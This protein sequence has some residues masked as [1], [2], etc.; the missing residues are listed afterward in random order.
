[1]KPEAH[2]GDLLRMAATAGRDP[3]SLLDFSVNVR[4]EGPPE[5]IRAALFRAMTALAAYPSPHAEEAMLAAAR[6]HGMD[7]SRFVFGSGSNELIHA[8]AR[9]LR[10]RGVPSVRVVEP[11]FSEYAIACRL[12]GIKAIPVW[13]GIIEKNQCVP[14]TDTG[15][16]EAVPTRDLLDALTDA[17]EGSAVFLANPGNPSG[18]FRTPEECLRLMSS[19]SDLLW[20]ID[21]AFVEYAGTETEASVL[22]RL[23]KNGI[24]LRS[25]TKFHAVPGV[26]LGYLA[27]DA[28][29]AQ[30]IRDEL[31]AWSVNAFALAAAQAVFADTSDFAAQTRAENAE[32]RADLA[33]ALSSLPGIEVYPSAANYVL[34]RWPGAPHN[35]LGI[36]LKRFGIAVR[37][38]SNYH[39]LKDGSW[40]RA[41]VRFPEDHRRLAEALSAIRETTHGVSSSP[42]PETPASPESGNKDSINIKVLGRGGMGAWGKGGESPS[43]EGFLLP[44]PGISRRPRHTPALMLQGTSSNAGKSILAAAYCRIFRQDGYSVAPF[45]AQNMSLNSGVT[46]AGDEMGRAQIVQAQAALVD[47]DAR[48][49]PILLKPHSDTGSQVVVLGQPIGHMGVLDYFKKKKELW[50]TVTEA[51]D[52]LAADHDVMVL[53]GA[54][55]PGEINLKEHDVVNMRMA[56]H[57]R[58]SVLLVGDIDRGGVYASFLG[59]WMTFTDAERRLL[60]GYIV[61]RFRGDASL[62][63]P[64]HEYMLDHTGTPVLG[65]IPYIR[66]LNI[67]EEDM[68]GFSWG[69]TDC[70]E[71]KAGTLDIAVVMLRHVSNYTDFAPLAAEPDVRLRPVRRAEEWGDPDVVMLPGSKSVVPDLDDLRRSGLADNILGHAER[72]KW[73]FGICGGL[74]ILGRAILDPH[75]IESAAPEVPGLGLMDLRSTFAAD[76]TLVRVARAETPLGVPSG[77]YEIHHGLTDHGPSALPLFLRADRAYPSEAE[78]ICGYVSGRRWATY[79]HGVFDDDAF[80]RAWLDHVRADIGLAPQGRQ[81]AAYDLEKALDRLADIVREH[82]DMETIY[83]SMGLK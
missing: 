20:I 59:T 10:K 27:A 11:A 23:P 48:M 69:H 63:G 28:E 46:A 3:A 44:S 18:L 36:L 8:L 42:L 1:M 49:N 68:A 22:Q 31:P 17:P 52:S 54:G 30:A 76:K 75:G 77:G 5:F 25:L 67:P 12:A 71:K 38:C 78:R 61:N 6:H 7:A 2:G 24:V 60:T 13:G 39:G 81:L 47:P 58:A 80:R 14:T 53:E 55:S 50:K 19:R 70:G 15:K 21:E 66:D 29:L 79:L 83:Q 73:I 64:A 37:D 26:R 82:S 62:L 9:V 43:P 33:A 56:E 51:Y 57:A 72:G 4:P 74:Q 40:F 35:L 16:D 41:A 65:T 34:F 45:K 32:R